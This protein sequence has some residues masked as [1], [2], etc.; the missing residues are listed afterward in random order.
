M[1]WFASTTASRS[2]PIRSSMRRSS[3]RGR[4]VP[5]TILL[6]TSPAACPPMP[7]AMASSRGPAY[8]ES[9]LLLRTSPRSERTAY[10]RYSAIARLPGSSRERSSKLQHR[11]ADAQR[12][13][14]LHWHRTV[15]L[16]LAEVRAVRRAEVLDDPH[17]VLQADAGVPSARVV[18]LEHERRVVGAADEHR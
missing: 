11:F 5:M 3:S 4:I 10:L 13:T 16:A 18:V 8:T 9:S 15:D 17:A 7:S 1:R 2:E 14:D 12:D 6:A